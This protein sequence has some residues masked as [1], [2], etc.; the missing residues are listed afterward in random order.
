MFRLWRVVESQG[1]FDELAPLA[2]SFIDRLRFDVPARVP[3]GVPPWMLEEPAILRL[4]MLKS[5]CK[6]SI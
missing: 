3:L 2:S 4:T 1:R 5:N 6:M